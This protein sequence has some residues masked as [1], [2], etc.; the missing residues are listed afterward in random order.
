MFS[1]DGHVGK[2]CSMMEMFPLLLAIETMHLN[3]A[4]FLEF[5]FLK[6]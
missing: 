6:T 4:S 3:I 5:E 1:G 2:E